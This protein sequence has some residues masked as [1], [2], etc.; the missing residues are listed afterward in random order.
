MVRAE[1]DLSVSE[2]VPPAADLERHFLHFAQ[3]C[4]ESSPLYAALSS[5]VANHP[6]VMQLA[7]GGQDR[8][9]PPNLLF[10]AIHYLLLGGA[11]HALAGFYPSIG[12]RKFATAEAACGAWPAFADFCRTFAGE[13]A[14]L[15]ASRRVQTNEVGR[16]GALLPAFCLAFD[17]L[18]RRPLH[19]IDVGASAGLNLLFDRY[20][21]QYSR[22]AS[23]SLVDAVPIGECGPPAS[24]LVRTA[25]LEEAAA[26]P[27]ARIA[28]L[29]APFRVPEA[30]PPVADRVGVDVSP[31]DVLDEPA[32]RWIESM[33]WADQVERIGLFR[34][35]VAIARG[36]PPR[37]IRGDAMERVP[38]LIGDAA[39]EA[40]PCIFHSHAIYQMSRE[41]RE[42]FEAMLT[43][44]S[45]RRDL[46]HV[47]LEWLGDDPGPRLHLSLLTGGNRRVVH[48]ADVHHHG[49][50]LRWRGEAQT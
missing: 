27:A 23:E 25:V 24:A 33:I 32:M 35:A 12:G 5:A 28:Q 43:E 2:P 44:L 7:A 9:P 10:G 22:A 26:Q 49:K 21:Y 29:A 48:V 34:A 50:W 13:I 4:S 3:I 40:L 37:V 6:E 15:V 18:G 41:W 8:Q 14:A 20:R 30:M 11:R 31:V 42:G 46:A 39:P 45:R 17:R 47:S 19:L 16:C 38:E 1:S 36:S